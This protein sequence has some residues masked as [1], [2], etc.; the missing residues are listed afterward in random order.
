M[1]DE[2]GLVITRL[3]D[4]Q[5]IDRLREG[6]PQEV[7]EF[8]PF[9]QLR[10]FSQ[11]LLIF[12]VVILIIFGCSQLAL[13]TSSGIAMAESNS[14]LSAEYGPWQYLLITGFRS[15]IIEEIRLDRENYEITYESYNDPVEVS[16]TWVEDE[17]P[18]IVVAQL[19]AEETDPTEE[20]DSNPP[21]T[22][23]PFSTEEPAG[24][25]ESNPTT[26]SS[27]TEI[28]SSTSAATSSPYETPY[29]TLTPTQPPSISTTTPTYTPS[30]TVT[31][32]P[33]ATSTSEPTQPPP[34]NTATQPPP[35]SP[36]NYCANIRYN[37]VSVNK[38]RS[39]PNRLWKFYMNILNNNSISMYLTSYQVSWTNDSDLH[40]NRAKAI[41]N[42]DTG[43]RV[44]LSNKRE[45]SPSSGCTDCPVEFVSQPLTFDAE[46]YNM[47]CNDYPCTETDPQ[48]DIP[49]GT[50]NFTA[51]GVFT[52]YPPGGGS[53]SCPFTKSASITHP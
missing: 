26:A 24:T 37:K 9:Y 45:F 1:D 10:E 2:H 27:S 22:E 49:P 5:F 40:L 42:P 12:P 34:T 20:S 38:Q 17:L 18:P 35:T 7:E 16:S 30:P 28:P 53:V 31:L 11:L 51:T 52:L 36:P 3:D 44:K 47:F 21:F 33:S 15:E 48:N 23:A 46:V 4:K 25:S 29:Q 6:I 19:P 14:N 8:D 50:Y 13:L 32:V 43:T 41:P 39:S